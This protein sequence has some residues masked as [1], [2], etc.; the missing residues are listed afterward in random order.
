MGAGPGPFKLIE[1][2]NMLKKRRRTYGVLNLELDEAT[3][4]G[5]HVSTKFNANC[6]IINGLKPLDR[7][8]Q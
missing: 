6:Q 3:V 2:G 4:D 5:D 1:C 7:Q 8:L